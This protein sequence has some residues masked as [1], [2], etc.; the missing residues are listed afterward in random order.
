MEIVRNLIETN[1]YRVLGV[2]AGDS[3]AVEAGHRSR[4]A[5]FSKVGQTAS[6]VLRG[7]DVLTPLKR[8]GEMADKAAQALSLPAER[9]RYSLFWYA[10]EEKHP[11]ASA[12]NGAVDSLLA[13]NLE[14][15]LCCYER[16]LSDDSLL[17]GFAESVTHGI[18]LV[19]RGGVANML[20]DTLSEHIGSID[21]ALFDR[22][23]GKACYLESVFFERKV[24]DE[25]N[26]LIGT[27]IKEDKDFY[28]PIDSLRNTTERIFP[29]INFARSVFSAA[30]YRFTDC[31]E[32]FACAVYEQGL[33]V[34]T[35]MSDWAKAKKPSSPSILLLR[36]LLEE[37]YEFVEY[38]VGRLGLN[39]CSCMKM[40]V[41][42]GRFED[43]RIRMG[44][45]LSLALKRRKRRETVATVLWAV[46][47]I[48]F[49]V[50]T[51]FV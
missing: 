16:L 26:R 34:L 49:F 7:D 18:S 39:E 36:G 37:V 24:R 43:A 21:G 14:D 32:D 12:I 41:F 4:I 5:A 31:A 6:F 3:V 35:N 19:E 8:D 1:P 42:K 2:Y 28:V 33:N 22:F 9:L 30:D 17:N 51:F 45:E 47:L 23:T 20:I 46:P 13:G 40:W 44:A 25:L 27:Y 15:A 29:Y 38:S 50:I 48:L 10:D 11:W